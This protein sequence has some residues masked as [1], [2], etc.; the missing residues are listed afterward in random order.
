MATADRPAAGPTDLSSSAMSLKPPPPPPPPPA[1]A[2]ANV[3]VPA[4][5]RPPSPPRPSLS[6][7][8][9]STAPGPAAGPAFPRWAPPASSLSGSTIDLGPVATDRVV[10]APPPPPSGADLALVIVGV[11][12]LDLTEG[13]GSG[14]A[15]AVETATGPA[16]AV[17]TATIDLT[18]AKP[19]GSVAGSSD[20][21]HSAAVTSVLGRSADE[22][23]IARRLIGELADTDAEHQQIVY[24]SVASLSESAARRLEAGQFSP[25]PGSFGLVVVQELLAEDRL[26]PAARLAAVLLVGLGREQGRQD[27]STAAAAGLLVAIHGQLDKRAQRDILERNQGLVVAF[28]QT[29]GVD[30][31]NTTGAQRKLSWLRSLGARNRTLG[32]TR[33]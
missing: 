6:N 9:R 2:L 20:S 25:S 7:M 17:E 14:P 22:G 30:H 28:R 24:R 5:R 19:P 16:A 11:A 29:L 26:L 3:T 10:L 18:E 8:Y 32:P 21:A 13:A 4:H 27:P 31:P 12:G 15:A 33:D 1:P 23:R